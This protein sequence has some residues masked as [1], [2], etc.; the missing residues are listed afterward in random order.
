MELKV[1]TLK[2]EEPAS[3]QSPVPYLH[4]LARTFSP[5]LPPFL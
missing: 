5:A 2:Q 4:G 1:S 3:S